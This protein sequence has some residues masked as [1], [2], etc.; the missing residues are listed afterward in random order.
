M[1]PPNNTQDDTNHNHNTTTD[2]N[3][4]NHPLYLHPND[5]PGLIL[6]SKKLTRSDNYSSWKRSMMI[7]LNAKNKLKIVTGEYVEPSSD[8]EERA[9]WERTNDMIISWILNTISDQIS[10]NLNFITTACDL[11]SELHEHYA[12]LDGHRIYQLVN[13]IVGLKQ[14]NSSIEVYYH[15]LKGLWDEHDAL[16]APYLC[17]CVCNCENGKN[18]GDR[19]QRKR[20]IQFLMGLDEC[21]ANLRGQILLLQPLPTVS[22]AYSMIRQEEK[23]REGTLPKP[24]GSTAFG[25]QSN[26]TQFSNN[27]FGN[28]NRNNNS[29]SQERPQTGRRSSFKTGV[30]CTNCYKEGHTS[31]ECYRLKG[32]PIGHPL[33]GKYKPPVNRN[34]TENRGTRT[35]NAVQG[36]DAGSTSTQAQAESSAGNDAVFVKMDQLQNQLNQV[37]LMMQ[38]CQ[39]SPPSGI[40][41]S[42][43]IRRHKFIA[44][45]MTKFKAAWVVDSGATDHICITLSIMHDTYLS[46]PPIHVT[47][48][49]GQTVEVKICGKVRI[50][51]DITLTNVFHIPSFAYNL[52]SVSQLTRQLPI[53]TVFT[54][55][56]CYFQGL[57]KRIAHG[58][59]YEGLYIIY[60]DKHTSTNPTILSTNSSDNTILWHSRLGHPSLPVLKH[61]KNIS[62]SC[63]DEISNCSVCPLAKNHASPFT[64]STSHASF[65]FELIHVDVWG[66]YKSP[67]INKCKYFLTIVDDFSRATWTYLIPSKDHA[68]SQIK[69]FCSYVSNH[70]NKTIKTIRSDNG[71]EFLNSSLITFLEHHGIKHQTTCPY[72]PQQNARVER[73]HKQLLEVARALRFQA[74][75]PIHFWGHCILTATYLIN[76]LPSKPIHNK[77]PFECLYGE[78]PSLDHLRVVGCQTF[79]HQ[80]LHDKF[81][82]RAISSVFVGY[83]P[84]QKDPSPD[85]STGLDQS[86]STT[87]TP[88][89]PEPPPITDP[90]IHTEPPPITSQPTQTHNPTHPQLRTSTR[91]SK[92]PTKLHDYKITLPKSSKHHYTNFINYNNITSS[93]IRHQINTINNIIEPQSYTQA[94]KNPKWIDAMNL[95]MAALEANGTWII[96]ELPPGKIPIGCRWVYRI[97][98]KADGSIDKYKARLVAKGFTQQEGVDY[99][100]T[101]APVANMVTVRALLAVAIHNQWCIAQ[102]DINNAFLHGDLK[103]EVYMKIPPGYSAPHTKTSVCKLQRS[104]YGLKQANRQWFIKLTTFLQHLGYVDDIIL[105]G[106][107]ES[108]IISV[109]QQ[110][111]QEFSVKDLGSLHYYL[112]IEVLRNTTGLVMTQRKYTLELIQSAGLLDVKPSSTPFDPLIK[113]NHDDGDLIDDPSQ[114]RALVGKLLYLTIT[115]PDISYAA[116]TLSQ[117]SQAHHTYKHLSKRSVTGYCIFLGSCLISWQSKKQGVVSRSSTEAEYRALADVTCEISWIKCLFKDLAIALAL[118]PV[119]HARTKHIEIDCHFVRDKIKQ[120]QVLPTFIPTR[121]QL[122]DV[123]TKGLSKAPHYQCLSKYGICD[124]Y[125]LPSC[126]EGKGISKINTVSSTCQ[127]KLKAVM[128]S[129][130]HQLESE[131]LEEGITRVEELPSYALLTR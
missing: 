99:H 102:L 9:M 74:N 91:I 48:P 46:S 43:T 52:L 64:L 58:N 26:P 24:L 14:Q 117:F 57:N 11:W 15:K 130:R 120:G 78:P 35:V 76:R 45:I 56:S 1:A 55:L 85:H 90:P 6:I 112:G 42:S 70:F 44:S 20:L 107:N 80:H 82:P 38:Q 84:S 105:T 83:P 118:S 53:T 128:K 30:Y 65:P 50:N 17:N 63:N 34:V 27:R 79:A 111:H 122:A 98:F 31:D 4:P 49:N 7:A 72:T 86:Q 119:Q 124:P 59:L 62:V 37:M 123:L 104:L 28:T 47:L 3:S 29:Q 5:H 87:E 13:D 121:H 110:L 88:P 8:S 25:A 10:N 12:Q 18:N 108:Y 116:Q 103:E 92:L 40:V 109:K 60:P 129:T 61:I 93:S 23:Q 2:L 32:Y 54:S 69:A 106:N 101:F 77:S 95:E 22:K 67:T 21:Y 100:E 115:I 16:E 33:L 36:Q 94:A 73:K 113:L 68:T 131:L 97:K 125:T 66:P 127:P 96:V 81:E 89:I 51:T 126:G 19:E 71:L 114:Y 39:Q 75:F 41:N